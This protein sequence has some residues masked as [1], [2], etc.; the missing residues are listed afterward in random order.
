MAQVLGVW[1]KRHHD[2]E[3]IDYANDGEAGWELCQRTQPDLALLDIELPKIDGLSLVQLLTEKFP[4][5]RV[6]MMSGLMDPYTIWRVLQSGVHGYIDKTESPDRLMEEIRTVA[7]G[8]TF[9]S[10]IFQQVKAEWLSQ[11]EAFQKILSDREQD[12]LRRVV[13]GAEDDQIGPELSI[14]A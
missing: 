2:L 8:G 4:K 9:F 6:L 1:I 7:G 13:A 3:L 11:P 5:M 10:K 14:S 12:I